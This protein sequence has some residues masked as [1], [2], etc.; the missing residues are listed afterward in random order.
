MQKPELESYPHWTA[1]GRTLWGG[2]SRGKGD[3]GGGGGGGA[4]KL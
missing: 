1:V 4:G 3:G 2:S